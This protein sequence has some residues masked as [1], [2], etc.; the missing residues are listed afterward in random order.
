MQLL[1]D[2]I[3]V[4][5]V[6]GRLDRVSRIFKLFD[7]GS[8][9]FSGG[10][11][12]RLH[13]LYESGIKAR[14]IA[15]GDYFTQSILTPI[16]KAL[17]SIVKDHPCDG[18]FDQDGAFEKVKSLTSKH[19]DVYSLDLSKATDRLPAKFQARILDVLFGGGIGKL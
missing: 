1:A 18:T 3:G 8:A 5:F 10:T 19:T 12:S 16:H 13:C 11:H 15:I 14:I 7:V 2:A 6:M 17:A 4:S 9:D